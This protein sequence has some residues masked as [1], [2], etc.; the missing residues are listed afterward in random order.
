MSKSSKSPLSSPSSFGGPRKDTTGVQFKPRRAGWLRLRHERLVTNAETLVTAQ[1][2]PCRL[3]FLAPVHR[4]ACHVSPFV[5]VGEIEGPVRH[6]TAHDE[7]RVHAFLD[8][9]LPIGQLGREAGKLL[10]DVDGLIRTVKKMEPGDQERL[11]N[12]LN[13]VR[14]ISGRVL[15]LSFHTACVQGVPLCRPAK[16]PVLG[17]FRKLVQRRKTAAGFC[18]APHGACEARRR[19]R[20]LRSTGE[21]LAR[22]APRYSSRNQRI[23]HLSPSG[24][25]RGKEGA[26]S[27]RTR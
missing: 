21:Q 13:E 5:M 17:L 11:M 12:R 19:T 26:H 6:A 1:P 8:P 15:P 9:R 14:H 3:P 20:C 25:R 22:R 27:I 2:G 10:V 18:C 16:R 4:P 7:T 24:L 23:S